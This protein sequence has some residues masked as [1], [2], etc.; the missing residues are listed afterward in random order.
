MGKHRFD[1]PRGCWASNK[2]A[3]GRDFSPGKEGL[4]EESSTEQIHALPNRV[5]NQKYY[6]AD[7]LS[8]NRFVDFPDEKQRKIT[9]MFMAE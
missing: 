3:A 8:V 9:Q 1:L 7:I 4:P 6:S 5:K 2:T